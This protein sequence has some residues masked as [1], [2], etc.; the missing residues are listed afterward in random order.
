MDLGT[1]VLGNEEQDISWEDGDVPRLACCMAAAA[2]RS[3]G[4]LFC[5]GVEEVGL[6]VFLQPA[7]PI[8]SP[9]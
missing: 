9:G 2:L 1:T 4:G 7:S 8:N 3:Q 5:S 6:N